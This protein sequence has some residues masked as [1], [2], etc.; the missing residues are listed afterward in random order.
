MN[1]SNQELYEKAMALKNEIIEELKKF[2]I[3]T[4]DI[5]KDIKEPIK[6]QPVQEIQP[7]KSAKETFIQDYNNNPG[8]YKHLIDTKDLNKSAA[9]LFGIILKKI[10]R[11][12]F[13]KLLL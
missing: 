11:E 5:I 7:P 6:P 8:K 1:L 2:S 10:G 12:E 3:N 4:E 9:D 13:K